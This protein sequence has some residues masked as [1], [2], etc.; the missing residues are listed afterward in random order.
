MLTLLVDLLRS[1]EL[2]ELA[3]GGVW[4]AFEGCLTGRPSLAPVTLDL[5]LIELT[6]RELRAIGSPADWV[7]ISRGKAGGGMQ[8]LL[9]PYFMTRLFAGQAARPDLA[10]IVASGLFDMC[11][12]TVRAFAAA[13]VAGLEDTNHG[14]VWAALGFLSKCRFEPGCEGK[15]R[16]AA[17]ALA[18]CLENSLDFVEEA[19]QTTGTYSVE[20]CVYTKKATIGT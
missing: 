15:I 4:C 14:V 17:V 18:F 11:V 12:E 20:Q 3:I 2:P 6:V 13:G 8:A 7:S 5:G 10:A 19:G 9:G 16:G 1:G